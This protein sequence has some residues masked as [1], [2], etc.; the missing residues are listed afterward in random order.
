MAAGAPPALFSAQ[1]HGSVMMTF[2]GDRERLDVLDERYRLE[3]VLGRGGMAE[4]H[5]SRDLVLDRDVAVKVL[6]DSV[7]DVDR[8]RFVGE[9]RTL[10][11]LSHVNLVT[12]LDA[13]ITAERPFLVMEL[14]R[15]RTLADA[16]G[17][18]PLPPDR[19]A[20]L[21]AQLAAALAYAHGRGVVHRDVKP[22]NV[23][24]DEEGR[25]KLADFGIAKLLG[26]TV[27]HTQTGTTIGTAAYLSPEQVQGQPVSGASDVY[28]LGLVLLEALTGV[29]AYPGSATEAALARLHRAP[30]IPAQLPAPWRALLAEMT[31]LDPSQRP[32]AE[33]LAERLAGGLPDEVS[34][35]ATADPGG[36]TQVLPT[37][38]FDAAP[39]VIDR[40]GD[41]ITRGVRH[42]WRRVVEAPEHHKGVAA[43]VLLIV[44]LIV[45]AAL[46]AGGSGPSADDD[47]P[48][49]TPAEMRQPLQDLHDA[50]E[51]R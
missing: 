29:R 12:V 34:V 2:S 4:V 15:G 14:V 9:A 38:S 24:V 40:A 3:E 50:V 25:V 46:A 16:L 49:R 19:V 48:A 45:V 39:P 26:E 47:L 20:A 10:A 30:E 51:D 31:S 22:A 11:G 7:D 23:L 5:R 18:G 41:A 32:T 27:R 21:G 42:G 33:V 36:T 1:T 13:G 6:R 37:P 17:D 28:S 35:D 44:L 43:A 8:E